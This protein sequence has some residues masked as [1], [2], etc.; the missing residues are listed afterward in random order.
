MLEPEFVIYLILGGGNKV[1]VGKTS[2]IMGSN[3]IKTI[4]VNE[5]VSLPVQVS[6]LDFTSLIESYQNAV[7]IEIKLQD[8]KVM[9]KGES[10]AISE[11]KE[12][13]FKEYIQFDYF[14][15]QKR[16]IRYIKVSQDGISLGDFYAVALK[17]K[18]FLVNS[19]INEINGATPYVLSISNKKS[20]KE[21]FS[22]LSSN[23]SRLQ[24][25]RWF[26]SVI[27]DNGL[28]YEPT[29]DKKVYPG[30]TLKLGYYGA[31]DILPAEQYE[32]VVYEKKDMNL[33]SGNNISFPLKFE[34][35][36]IIKFTNIRFSDEV[37]I[38]KVNI[39]LEKM[40]QKEV[41]IE[42]QKAAQIG[43]KDIGGG[44]FIVS[45]DINFDAPLHSHHLSKDQQQASIQYNSY[46]MKVKSASLAVVKPSVFFVT[47]P[48]MKPMKEKYAHLLL[49]SKQVERLSRIFN[50]YRDIDY[51]EK[52]FNISVLS[53]NTDLN[54]EDLFGL[55][56]ESSKRPNE[57][58]DDFL[59]RMIEEKNILTYEVSE[60]IPEVDNYWSFRFPKN[61]LYSSNVLLP[62]DSSVNIPSTTTGVVLGDGYMISPIRVESMFPNMRPISLH[63][64]D[65]RAFLYVKNLPS[66]IIFTHKH[67]TQPISLKVSGYEIQA[68]MK[69][70]RY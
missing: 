44:T 30:Y 65:E 32:P 63:L 61:T 17:K 3:D 45:N 40:S 51:P 34:K 47:P 10:L 31:K 11:I 53:T 33:T 58:L 12:H 16:T 37:Y 68:D 38:N 43:I 28:V 39:S 24:W 7:G 62:A 8:L 21:L 52:N 5:S 13:F 41:E 48:K 23:E 35:G 60:S 69:V 46:R 49:R 55:I 1:F 14:D 20:N 70:L 36:D 67:D 56:L 59:S 4:G 54:N 42:N 29:I 6:D 64:T 66:R 26:S 22:N 18:S 9:H 25:R 15:G 27:D 2:P 19:N 57:N 50:H